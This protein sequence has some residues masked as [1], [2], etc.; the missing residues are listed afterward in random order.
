MNNIVPIVFSFDD[1]YALPASIAI[2]SLI[3]TKNPQTKYDIFVL[4]KKLNKSIMHK[5]EKIYKINWI[6]VNKKIFKKAPKC[7][8][9]PEEVYYRL[10][11]HELIPQ[12][13]KIIWSDVDVLFK[14][15]LTDIYE[16]QLDDFF[17]AGIAAERNNNKLLPCSKKL[18][19]DKKVIKMSGH[20][21]YKENL[22]E[23]IFMSGFMLINAKKMRQMNMTIKFFDIIKKY[24]KKLVMFDLEI[25]NL[26]CNKIKALPFEYCVLEN[27]FDVDNA[28]EAPEYP[29]LSEIYTDD[30]LLKAKKNPAIIHYTGK[31][32]RIWN[33][34]YK[35]IP[36]NYRLYIINSPFYNRYKYFYIKENLLKV[37]LYLKKNIYL[38]I[39]RIINA[40]IN[41]FKTR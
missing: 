35:S 15:D 2:Q 13:E 25:L 21:K 27:I 7:K 40:K 38:K 12:Y 28:Q 14:R 3:D 23:F 36:L 37:K 11:I 39:K 20:T 5:I 22:N 4:Y 16:T 18:K 10:L 32:V 41:I 1:K 9:Y 31:N 30:E 24:Y 33:R 29:F 6:K 17:W 8:E 19:G 26:A 34:R